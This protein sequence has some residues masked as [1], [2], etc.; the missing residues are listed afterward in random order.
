MPGK[1]NGR[2]AIIGIGLRCEHRAWE[3]MDTMDRLSVRMSAYDF[4]TVDMDMWCGAPYTDWSPC[5]SSLSGAPISRIG[6]MC[7]NPMASSPETLRGPGPMD[8]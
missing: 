8:N 7:L 1:L 4:K 6:L 5:P 2:C 3:A